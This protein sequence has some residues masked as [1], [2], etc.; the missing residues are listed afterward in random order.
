AWNAQAPMVAT[1]DLALS[2][3]GRHLAYNPG[4]AEENGLLEV[5]DLRQGRPVAALP[6]C[7]AACWSANGLWLATVAARPAASGIPSGEVAEVRAFRPLA[8]D[9]PLPKAVPQVVFEPDGASLWAGGQQVRLGT[10]AGWLAL[11]AGETLPGRFVGPGIGSSRWT[12]ETGTSTGSTALDARHPDGRRLL[13]PVAGGLARA[14]FLPDGRRLLLAVGSPPD[15][16]HPAK[17]EP[18]VTNRIEVWDLDQGRRL[19]VWSAPAGA[20]AGGPLVCS[21]DGRFVAEAFFEAEAIRVLDAA[22]GE[23]LQRCRPTVG[24]RNRLLG[25]RL[26]AKNRPETAPPRATA[27][28]FSR[29]GKRLFAGFD[30]GG[31][32]AWSIPSGQPVAEAKPGRAAIRGLA[33]DPRGRLLATADLEG[34]ITLWNAATGRRVADWR[35]PGRHWQALAFSPD[36][37]LLAAGSEEGWVQVWPLPGLR[38][39][40]A[41]LGLAER[42]PS[43]LSP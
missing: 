10:P 22:S 17:I 24:S 34:R 40:L 12:L 33:I 27:L 42:W 7:R 31:W 2:P 28:A 21:P 39:E 29:E 41:R 9:L 6:G 14:A 13:L 15:P 1:T 25:L 8:P 20:A 4:L 11:E 26:S 3:D 23:V 18:M 43:S 30:H 16:A 36:G 5:M 35:I 32:M 19:A 38:R 37:A